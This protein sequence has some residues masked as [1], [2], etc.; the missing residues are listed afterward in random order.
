MFS[1]RNKFYNFVFQ[2]SKSNYKE[3]VNIVCTYLDDKILHN[4][5]DNLVLLLQAVVLR[6]PNVLGDI[7]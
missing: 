7:L 1:T 5:N 2:S 6:D 3:I 4:L